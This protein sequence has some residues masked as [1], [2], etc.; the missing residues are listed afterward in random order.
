MENVCKDQADKWCIDGYA[1]KVLGA[2]KRA[3]EDEYWRHVIKIA[4]IG[5]L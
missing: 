2:I 1:K 3:Q 5:M 4:R